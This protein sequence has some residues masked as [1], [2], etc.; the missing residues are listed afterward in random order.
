MLIA[1]GGVAALEAALALDDLAGPA[2]DVHVLAPMREFVYRPLAVGEPFGWSI[3][4]RRPVADLLPAAVATHLG[5]TLARV[6][7]G[8]HR[9]ETD[10]GASLDYDALLVATGARPR[11]VIPGALSFGGP[12]SVEE[13]RRLLAA[14]DAGSVRRVAF[15][16]PEQV[17]WGLPLYEL[18]LMT[19]MHL[20]ERRIA[21]VELRFVTHEQEPLG[22]FRAEG[23]AALL[24]R[25]GIALERGAL[26]P[27]TGDPE[28]DVV[29]TLP[30][31]EGPRI[32]GLPHDDEGF[33]AVDEHGRVRAVEAVWAAGDVTD[34]PIKQGGLATQQADA[35]A[36]SIAAWAGRMVLPTPYRPVLRGL[37]LTGDW[38]EHLLA[39]LDAE[40]H[41]RFAVRE[42][43][44]WWPEAKIAGRYLGP[45]LSAKAM[46]QTGRSPRVLSPDG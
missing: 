7:P 14:L 24:D 20:V 29:V 35:A 13:Y 33:L 22:A 28:C 17:A 45:V 1:G 46:D 40:G 8:E 30:Q 31:L 23:I 38:P 16:L 32:A 19:A 37:L 41:G 15:V 36:E 18:A 39:D 25:N 11:N 2:L 9:I 26:S 43:P 6:V 10:R 42:E 44:G 4:S 3:V 27:P 12:D 5:E 21:G 34:H